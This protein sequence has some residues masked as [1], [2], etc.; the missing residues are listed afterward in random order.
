VQEEIEEEQH[1]SV[2]MN[3]VDVNP[4]RSVW[5]QSKVYG[6]LLI[7]PMSIAVHHGSGSNHCEG[8]RFYMNCIGK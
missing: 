8:A 6:Y 7:E 4:L 3:R 2:Y 1:K 5:A